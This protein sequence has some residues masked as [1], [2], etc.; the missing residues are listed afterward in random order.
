MEDSDIV[1]RNDGNDVV[2]G[3]HFGDQIV[4]LVIRE[5]MLMSRILLLQAI[6]IGMGNSIIN[7]CAIVVGVEAFALDTD[8]I[9]IVNLYRIANFRIILPVLVG[10][11][12][13]GEVVFIVVCCMA[14]ENVNP[15]FI[16]QAIV[17][18][19]G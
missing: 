17:L 3:M 11:D 10:S 5:D 15:Y 12:V 14:G 16:I 1:P 7:S 18:R 2:Y 4:V 13:Y 19:I 9:D 6:V 8:D